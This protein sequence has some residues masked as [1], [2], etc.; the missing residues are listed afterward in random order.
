MEKNS[1]TQK[2]TEVQLDLLK[3]I[4]DYIQSGNN[5]I[6]DVDI[7]KLI[8]LGKFKESEWDDSYGPLLENG[9]IDWDL[10]THKNVCFWLTEKGK[11]YAD[12]LWDF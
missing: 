1:E 2:L 10:Y 9:Y 6:H 7:D 5:V 12:E 3:V 11:K 8:E 4:Y